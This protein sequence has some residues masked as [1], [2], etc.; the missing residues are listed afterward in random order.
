K[1][2]DVVHVEL[3]NPKGA[4]EK[5]L[6]LQ[7]IQGIC[8]GNFTIDESMPGGIYK[9]KAYTNWMQNFGDDYFFEKELIVQKVV[10][11]RVLSKLDF[12]KGTVLKSKCFDMF[13]DVNDYYNPDFNLQNRI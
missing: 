5:S 6:T 7:T 10:L 9:I 4:V 1:K 13:F 2:S 3:I 12:K 11:T 8:F